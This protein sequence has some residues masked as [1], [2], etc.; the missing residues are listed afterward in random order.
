[1]TFGWAKTI[2]M[3]AGILSAGS[4]SAGAV[5]LRGDQP[6]MTVTGRTAQPIGHYEFCQRY[7]A[8]C[9]VRSSAERR[10][11]PSANTR[12]TWGR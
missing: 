7:R 5:D 2:L 3:A 12:V 10:S 11:T 9:Q 6:F 4:I 1:M 8:E